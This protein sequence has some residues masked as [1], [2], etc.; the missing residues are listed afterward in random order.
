MS[1]IKRSALISAICM[2]GSFFYGWI[3]FSQPPQPS[4]RLTTQPA[5]SQIRP[6]EAEATYSQSPIRLTFQA[7]DGKGHALENAKMHLQILTPPK[8]PWFTTDFPIVEGTT[9]LDLEAPA[10]KG[11]LQIQETLP[12][13]G[14]YQFLVK[15]TP[16]VPNAFT[17][18]QQTLTLSVSE[19]WVKY[20][21]LAILAAILLCVGL[22][23]GWAI[24][25]RQ[26]IQPGEI[27]PQRVRLLLSGAIVVAIAALL[28]VNVSAEFAQSHMSMAMSHMTKDEPKSDR[29]PKLQS[30]GLELQ[31]S[32]DASATVGQLAKLQ[33]KVSDIKT[34]QPVTDVVLKVTTTQ[35]EKNWVAFAYEG[36]PDSTG[37]LAWQQQFF[38]G[39][40]HRIKAEIVPQSITKRQFQPF[41]VGQDISVEGVAPP[42]SVRL[43]SLTYF[44][45]IVGM[46]LLLGLKLRWQRSGF[47]KSFN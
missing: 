13:R 44:T 17:P 37:K 32:G 5:I 28:F 40:P 8:N 4:V 25:S 24:G 21:N 35:L 9:L 29:P 41:Q 6:F 16:T 45:G 23:G 19:N 36:S 38:D 26:T 34:K 11:E 2:M 43:I 3:A 18:I 39:A 20:Q 1:T 47:Y 27:A 14:T 31:L 46:G 33:V 22:G 42:L 10:P 12:T 15:V 7:V 30:Q